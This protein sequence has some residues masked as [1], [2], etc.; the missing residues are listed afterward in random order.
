MTGTVQWSFSGLK[1]FINCPR[2]FHET[3][4]LRRFAKSQTEQMLYGTEVHKAL[5]DYVRDGSPLAKNYQRYQRMMDELLLIPGIRHPE[6]KMA[7]T[8]EHTSCEFDAPEYWVRGIVDLLIVDGDTAYIVDYKTGSAKYPDLKQLKLMALMTFAHHPEVV[9]I[10]AG[11]LF[12]AHNIFIDEEYNRSNIELLWASFT[13]HLLR[14]EAAKTS[15]NWTPNP[16]GLC[17]WCP[18]TTCEF[19]RER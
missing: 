5:E 14:L 3:K 13:P 17:G 1:D 9:R 6:R 15:G 7:L 12:V 4:V 11:L 8:K 2:Q 19:Y 18:V 10:K 16:T